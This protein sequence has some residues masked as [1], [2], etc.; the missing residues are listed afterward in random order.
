MKRDWELIR[1]ILLKVEDAD[2][3]TAG[4]NASDFPQHPEDSVNYHMH[5]LYQAGLIEG[6]NVQTMS[7]PLNYVV[8][9]L[10]WSG[11]EFLDS[12]RSQTV[13]ERIKTYLS[14]KGVA[15]SFETIKTTAPLVLKAILGG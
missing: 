13:W 15:I 11:H 10:T 5:L 7:R 9:R 3:A 12:V 4:I 1:E 14:E 2:S 8:R 6:M